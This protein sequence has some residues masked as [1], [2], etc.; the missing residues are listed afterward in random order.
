[1]SNKINHQGPNLAERWPRCTVSCLV[2]GPVVGEI[3]ERWATSEGGLGGVVSG[4]GRGEVRGAVSRLEVVLEPE[5][6]A[7][8]ARDGVQ[9][10]GS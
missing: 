3:A 10:V 5:E 9:P 1:M 7:G 8:E 2:E 4:E 6:D